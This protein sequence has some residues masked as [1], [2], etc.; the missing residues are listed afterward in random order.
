MFV[1]SETLVLGSETSSWPPLAASRNARPKRPDSLAADLLKVC[2][3][4]R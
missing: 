3:D 4:F 2:G 1:A